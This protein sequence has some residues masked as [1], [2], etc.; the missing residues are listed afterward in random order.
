[1]ERKS[2]NLYFEEKPWEQKRI[3]SMEGGKHVCGGWVV[4]KLGFV[5]FYTDQGRMALDEKG[6]KKPKS[7]NVYS[8]FLILRQGWA[9]LEDKAPGHLTLFSLS[10]V[11][12][13][14][15]CGKSISPRALIQDTQAECCFRLIKIQYSNMSI[16]Y[17][18]EKPNPIFWLFYQDIGSR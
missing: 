13:V 11:H 12:Q 1:M 10:P 2:K 16:V 9:S 18:K 14:I 17:P 6:V 5:V 3:V 8:I 4:R 7:K 15:F